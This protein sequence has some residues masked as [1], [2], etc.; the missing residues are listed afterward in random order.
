MPDLIQIIHQSLFDPARLPLAMVAVLLVFIGGML[1]G[2]V[3]G[4]ANPAFWAV[5]NRLFGKLGQRI[6]KPS[7]LKGDLIF[8]GLVFT[9]LALVI[10][11][12]IGRAF[13]QAGAIY[14][15]WSIVEIGGLCLVLSAGAVFV[16]SG[17]LYKALNDKKVTEGAYYTIA[18]STRTDMSR[19][20][21]YTIVRVGM[22]WVFRS[23]DK[24]VVAPV[25]WYLIAGLPGAY[26][27]AGL[28]AISW[29]FGVEGHH[30]G[31]AAVMLTLERLMGMIPN[32][33]SGILL[34]LAALITPTAGLSRSFLGFFST[35][36][37]ARYE[38]GGFP[39]SVAA[40][41]LN[42]SLGGPTTN[43][44]GGAIKRSW[45]GPAKAT[46]QLGAKHLHR[47][48]YMSFIAHLLLL[49]SLGGA[50]VFAGLFSGFLPDFGLF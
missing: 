2:P 29:R 39:V 28:I 43:L 6:D 12:L 26:L 22:G 44:D 50:M 4:N 45:I 48:L 25:V 31:F 15:F 20:D 10:A 16:A 18:R 9:I 24:A 27:Y 30:S 21:D 47:A 13:A 38:E 3:A 23:F 36:G 32:I 37:Q 34:S 14:P 11:F 40:Y 5:M 19:S 35:K 1:S 42:V 33:L 49:A 17:R 7:R 41:A 8:R 46:A